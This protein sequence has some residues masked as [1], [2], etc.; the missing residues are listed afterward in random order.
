[1]ENVKSKLKQW[2]Y[3]ENF[4]IILKCSKIIMPI[5]ILKEKH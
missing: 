2:N 4:E 1:M 5:L 3:S